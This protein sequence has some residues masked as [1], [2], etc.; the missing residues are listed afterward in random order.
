MSKEKLLG[1]IIDVDVEI[2]RGVFCGIDFTFKL[3]TGGV[4]SGGKYMVNM[5]EECKYDD[6]EHRNQRYAESMQYIY[7]FMKDAGVTRV[8][9]LK[10]LPV[11]VT[12]ENSTFKDFRFLK[13]VM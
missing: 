6:E 2:I 9:D 4:G 5:S 12:L 8:S 1:K 11:E 3:E 10:G 7:D 13:E